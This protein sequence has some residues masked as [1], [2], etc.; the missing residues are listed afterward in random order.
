VQVR[1]EWAGRSVR[2]GGCR[3]VVEAPGVAAALTVSG[4]PGG[5]DDSPTGPLA[6]EAP[7]A[8]TNGS[9]PAPAADRELYEFLAP[10]GAA[11]ELGRLGGYRV[12]RILGSGGMGVVFE[13]EDIQLRRPVALKALLPALAVSSAARERFLREARAA[14]AVA[15]DHVVT[16]YQVGEDRGIPFLAM[17]L[18]PGETLETRLR[19]EHRLPVVEVV[20][21]GREVAEGLAA[22]H[23]RGLIHRDIKPS[24]IWLES[25][26]DGRP[27]GRTEPTGALPVATDYRVK[28]LDFG[29]ARA[30]GAE[31]R[32][33]QS[34]AFV[35]T[36]GY[37]APEQTRGGPPDPR[38]DLFSLGCVLYRAC[39]G[40]PP[41]Q[42][43]DVL[44]IL[45]ALASEMPRPVRE[46]N[47]A[48][49]LPLAD[50]VRRLLAKDPAGRPG[51]AR[52]VIEALA[53]LEHD[54]PTEVPAEAVPVP[55][56]PPDEPSIIDAELATAEIVPARRLRPGCVVAA[57][58]AAVVVLALVLAAVVLL[59][60]LA[61]PGTPPPQ[62]VPRPEP[63]RGWPKEPF[64]AIAAGVRAHHY[65]Q[66]DAV[67]SRFPG[68]PFEDVPPE[69]AVLIGFEVGVGK[70]AGTRDVI[71]YLQPIF[72][73]AGG[74]KRGVARGR[75]TPQTRTIKAKPGFAVAGLTAR[76]AIQLDGF[77]VTFMEMGPAGLKKD[78]AYASEWVGGRDAAPVEQTVGGDGSLAVGICGR[79]VHDR[80]AHDDKPGALGLVMLRPPP[81]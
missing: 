81:P 63:P 17:Q 61:L 1:D 49:P 77:A 73:T 64:A 36:P 15:H 56:L 39:T 34:G 5:A 31:S 22:A 24:N 46:L 79:M 60:R 66:T 2:C 55:L 32:L 70:F 7:P 59:A 47:P 3:N 26:G 21:I 19:R 20:R 65:Q 45:A 28:L 23:E 30:A 42:G 33:T 4:A 18:L 50:L 27:A 69:G 41:F 57:V 78:T 11:D 75:P 29:L 16:I 14:A 9:P 68:Q 48:V 40:E 62:V 58:A 51:S 38:S 44:A 80:M 72:L 10:P 76:G 13:A 74:E 8:G 54:L 35:G 6:H 67:G 71:D 37:L 43:S 53:A 25:R 52:A 12:L